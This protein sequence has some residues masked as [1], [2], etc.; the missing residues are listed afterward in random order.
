MMSRRLFSTLSLVFI[1]ACSDDDS[2]PLQPPAP[3]TSDQQTI[4][5]CKTIRDA[6]ETY[7]AAHN[8]SYGQYD[9]SSFKQTGLDLFQHLGLEQME[10]AYT[11]EQ[12]P[13]TFRAAHPG[14][15]GIEAYTCGGA[16]SGYRITGY[17]ENHVLITL[18]A[19]DKVPA[20]VRYTHDVTVANAFLVMDAAMR[21]AETNDGVFS[22]DTC[23]DE[24]ND[25]KCLIQLLPNSQLLI[26]PF[27]GSHSEP[28][29]GLSLAFHG[30]IGYLGTDSGSGD[31]DSFTIESYECDGA[32]MLTLSLYSSFEELVVN[33]S[34][35]LRISI[36]MFATQSG[37]YP[38]NLDTE[39]TPGGKTVLELYG[40]YTGEQLVTLSNPYTKKHYVPSIGIADGKGAVAYQPIETA[41][42]VT[43]Y[44]VTA[45]SLFTELVRVGPMPDS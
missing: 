44:L 1:I 18:E 32:I 12:E 9:F 43:D 31:I 24:N 39:T 10:N 38:H 15:I 5:N 26:N 3:L 19:L 28:Q 35:S 6:L 23:G 11:G 20:D 40:E 41:G 25:G 17:G 37:H 4:A 42:V 14:Q 7:A 8:G 27:E 36:E 30:M 2:A 16:V 45:L 22:T 13:S 21:F 34:Y 33:S 29:D